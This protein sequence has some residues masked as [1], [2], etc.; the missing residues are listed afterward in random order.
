MKLI[1]H[2]NFNS[3]KIILA[4]LSMVML[5]SESGCTTARIAD[6]QPASPTAT[7]HTV[8]RSGVQIALDP[9]VESSRTEQ[10][11]DM[12]ALAN[13]IAILHVHITNETTNQTFLVEKKDFQLVPIGSSTGLTETST[14]ITSSTGR[15]LIT[16]ATVLYG[17]G[18][19]VVGVGFLLAGAASVS[20]SSEIQRNF[21]DKQ[22]PDETL[23]PGESMEGF[24]YFS[25]V[26]KGE[27]WSRTTFAKIDLQNIQT[28]QITELTI[29][30][31]H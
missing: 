5:F 3:K 12:D 31:S 16:T 6:Y 14:N 18:S 19:E 20:H 28:H 17:L 25:P 24:V 7:E 30:L 27:D 13:G 2:S 26:Q 4:S 29:L 23:S 10:Y 15:G 11:F 22:M 1:P 21:A 9:F 8:Q